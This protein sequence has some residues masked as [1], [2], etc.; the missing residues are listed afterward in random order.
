MYVQHA[1]SHPTTY[2]RKMAFYVN[3]SLP[4]LKHKSMYFH[5][6]LPFFF[7]LTGDDDMFPR[8]VRILV[9]I[10][11]LDVYGL[12]FGIYRNHVT[13]VPLSLIWT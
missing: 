5:P 3:L 6:H 8:Q 1:T 11:K 9:P 4:P 12:F 2:E 13:I 10:L 7:F